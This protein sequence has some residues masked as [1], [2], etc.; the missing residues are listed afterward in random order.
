MKIGAFS[1]FTPEYTFAESCAL[2]KSLGYAGVQPRI[3]EAKHGGFDPSKPFNPWSNGKGA[4]HEEVFIQ[5]PKKALQPALDAGL[6]ITSVASYTNTADMSRAVTMVKACG[7]VGIKNVRVGGLPMPSDRVFNAKAFLEKS[8]GTYKELVAEAKKAGV[9]P[10]LELHPGNLY[11]GASGA[12]NFLKPFDPTEVGILYDPA[13]SV[14]DGWETYPV[15]LNVM[16]AYLAEVHV[17][18]TRWVAGELTPQGTRKWKAEGADLEDGIV[19]WAELVG[20]LKDHK[21]SGWLVEEGHTANRSSHLR[22][23]MA[24]ELLAKLIGGK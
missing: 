22:L 18:N 10:C 9:R 24:H 23:K 6:E 13:N 3:C 11:P 21:F 20:W 7:K 12:M 14:G 15:A 8:Q 19:D 1:T 5:D 16:G 2:I 4:I 17:K